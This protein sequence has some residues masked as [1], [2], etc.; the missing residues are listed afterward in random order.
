M[1]K[2]LETIK[3]DGIWWLPD[4]KEKK[5]HGSLNI[6]C[7]G[8]AYLNLVSPIEENNNNSD[9][10][11]LIFGFSNDG[12]AISLQYCLVN[13]SPSV[14]PG[15]KTQIISVENVYITHTFLGDECKH[16]D[17]SLK[18]D[19]IVVQFT[20]LNDW[21]D[22][23]LFNLDV[24]K[25]DNNK[26]AY[27]LTH[28][29]TPFEYE[30]DFNF[31]KIKG[32]FKICYGFGENGYSYDSSTKIFAE[33]YFESGLKIEINQKL[34]IDEWFD[35]ILKP[36][37]EFFM[38]A[39]LKPTW[40]SGLSTYHPSHTINGKEVPIKIYT[41]QTVTS[42]PNRKIYSHEML[43]CFESIKKDLSQ[44]INKWF[45]LCHEF[46]YIFGAYFSTIQS[47]NMYL[48]HKF[49]TLA[50]TVEAY[51]RISN[52]L[53]KVEYKDKNGKKKVRE[54]YFRERLEDL[55]N[56]LKYGVISNII[57]D[58]NC[59]LD[60]VKDTRNFLTHLENTKKSNIASDQ[61]LLTRIAQLSALIQ[62][63]ILTKLKIP[64]RNVL[65]NYMAN[66]SRL[67]PKTK[68]T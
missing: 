14:Y 48:E 22:F 67:F 5:I 6:S 53:K 63:L 42:R 19:K 65:S 57:C 7:K 62:T 68:K 32:K 31:K 44:I 12:R 52:P 66:K 15:L 38:L 37:R 49:L 25:I 26:T 56:N 35:Y 17:P 36:I 9:E 46:G 64:D 21:L 27:K 23:P 55:L 50:Q 29:S 60:S 54:L 24:E 1:V 39:T 8:G 10:Y 43:F 59:F 34:N 47:N 58:A 45:T 16:Y 2:D 33:H 11:E 40:I 18:T 41:R 3:Y 51:H 4:N 61:E 20:Y 30:I 28:I 13:E